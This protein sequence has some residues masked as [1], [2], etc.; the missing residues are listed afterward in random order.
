MSLP[1]IQEFWTF[2]SSSYWKTLL[3]FLNKGWSFHPCHS[4]KSCLCAL[5][6]I[7]TCVKWSQALCSSNYNQCLT[8][9]SF[10]LEKYL[11][12]WYVLLACRVFHFH[13]I[14]LFFFPIVSHFKWSCS[15]KRAVRTS[16]DLILFYPQ[17][18]QQVWICVFLRFHFRARKI[19]KCN[20]LCFLG[21]VV[22][23]LMLNI[24]Y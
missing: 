4:Q 10:I 16:L 13:F 18:D 12:S 17:L 6:L 8:S 3:F 19:T 5:F 22:V 7:C 14:S 1:V 20:T 11:D 24:L 2:F 9:S 23:I 15:V 21:V